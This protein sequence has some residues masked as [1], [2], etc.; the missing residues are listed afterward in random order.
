MQ[1]IG[2]IKAPTER[3]RN[4]RVNDRG[5]ADEGERK[6][7]RHTNLCQISI[8]LT[9]YITLTHYSLVLRLDVDIEVRLEALGND[10]MEGVVRSLVLLGLGSG[11]WSTI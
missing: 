2:T 4:K 5:V 8:S 3:N 1:L 6:S 7:S 11:K 9:H 10:A